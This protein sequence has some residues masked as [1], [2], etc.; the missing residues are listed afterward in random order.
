MDSDRL[1]ALSRALDAARPRRGALA[2]ALGGLGLSGPGRS[3]G[4]QKRKEEEKE[5]KEEAI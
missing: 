5:E 1:D 2:V 4:R 3:G